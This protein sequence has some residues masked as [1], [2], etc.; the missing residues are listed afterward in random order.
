MRELLNL[1]ADLRHLYANL[2]NGA[3][4]DTASAKRIATG[5]LGP[6]IERLEAVWKSGNEFRP[7]HP[8]ASH[9]NPDYR[10]GWNDCY[11]AALAAPPAGIS[12]AVKTAVL[13]MGN[14]GALLS[15]CAFNL[16]QRKCV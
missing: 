15:N 6:A 4:R 7:Y 8:S 12:P 14:A 2:L 9:C 10:D 11:R 16:A 1:V 3:V 5:L 13:D